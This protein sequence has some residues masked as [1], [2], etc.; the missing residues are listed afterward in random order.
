MKKIKRDNKNNPEPYEDAVKFE[1]LDPY[2]S[3]IKSNFF[4]KSKNKYVE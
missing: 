3:L 4:S 1:Q 2:E